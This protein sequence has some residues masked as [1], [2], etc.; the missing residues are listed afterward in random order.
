MAADIKDLIRKVDLKGLDAL[1]SQHPELANEELPL[2]DNPAKAHPLHRLC[3]GV[4]SGIYSDKEAAEMAMIFLK[5]GAKI[6][7]NSLG[8][9]KDTPLIGAASLGA[10]EVALLYINSEAILEHGGCHGGTALHWAAWC[11]R[12]R[13][14]ER[15]L[16]E[17]IDLEKRCIDFNSTPLFWGVH[18]Y[19]FG[20]GENR[21]HQIECVRMLIE[22]GAEKHTAN[23]EGRFAI[24]LLSAEDSEMK[25]LLAS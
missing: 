22:A 9:K 4:H 16:R 24:E 25:A 14:V 5:H 12:D 21:Y 1:L 7:G 17:K 6:N 10:D 13:V 23:A 15:I 8:F 3:D 11:G 19:K 2:D 18:G 20:G